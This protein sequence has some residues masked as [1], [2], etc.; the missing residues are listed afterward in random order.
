MNEKKNFQRKGIILTL[1]GG[2]LWGFCGSCGQFL[3]Q[4]KEVTSGWL[5]PFRLTF[6][7]LLILLWLTLKEKGRVLDV[8]RE[9]EGRKDILIFSVFGM[10][11]CQ[12]SYFTTI[13]YSN[14]GTATVLQYTGPALILVW[15]CAKERKRPKAYELAALFC[16]MFGTFILATHGNVSEL[17]IP[18]KALLWGVISAVTLVIYTL[19]PANLMKKY[20]TLLTLGWGMLLGGL[21]LMLLMRPWTLSPV[22]DMQTV[23][24]MVFIVCFGTICAFDFYLTGVKLVGATSAS[25]LACIEPVAAAVISALWLKVRFQPVDFLGFVFVLSTV[26]IISLNQR[27][28]ELLQEGRRRLQHG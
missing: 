20:S 5:V 11:L 28:E 27:K 4:Y 26:F 17:A 6:A 7:G 21:V 23:L 16:S 1:L 14:A 18:G 25:M 19:Q 22:V 3:F 9:R 15:L 10:M 8:W 13:Q 2:T 24:A 12:Y